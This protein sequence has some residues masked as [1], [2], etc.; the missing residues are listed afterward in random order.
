MRVDVHGERRRAAAES[1]LRGLAICPAADEGRR[2]GA[3][4]LVG[5]QVLVARLGV[6]ISQGECIEALCLPSSE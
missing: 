5:L 4:E 1:V 3:P 2:L 6:G